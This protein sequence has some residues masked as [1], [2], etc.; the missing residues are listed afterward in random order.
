MGYIK[1][2]EKD[3]RNAIENW[4]I[5][6]KLDSTKTDLIKEIKKCQEGR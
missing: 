4:N 2:K 1:K 6:L 3:C 5:A